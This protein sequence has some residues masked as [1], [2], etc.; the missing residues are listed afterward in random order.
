LLGSQACIL[1]AVGAVSNGHAVQK[2]W[3][4]RLVARSLP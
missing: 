3:T 4:C 1:G 2:G